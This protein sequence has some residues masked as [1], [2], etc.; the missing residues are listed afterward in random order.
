VADLG[1]RFFVRSDFDR[2]V[3]IRYPRVDDSGRPVLD[4]RGEPVLSSISRPGRI[5]IEQVGPTC[6]ITWPMRSRATL[7]LDAWFN[8]QHVR[9][10]LFGTLPEENADRI[11]QAGR[12]G[13]KTIIPNVS[14]SV[15]WDL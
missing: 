5:W 12:R 3:S 14:L 15:L 8:V 10:R 9:R 4:E 2:S 11:R 13:S 6:S 7:P 1:I